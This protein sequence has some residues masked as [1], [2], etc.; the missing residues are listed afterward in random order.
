MDTAN[1]QEHEILQVSYTNAKGEPSNRHIIP[2]RVPEDFI[3]AVD[4]SDLDS[5]KR[6]AMQLLLKE[7]SKYVNQSLETIHS[8]EDWFEV[9]VGQPI[10]M[11]VKWRTFKLDKLDLI[12][13]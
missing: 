12:E 13:E 11:D 9:T 1:L 5:N 3:K 8:F 6:E 10:E 4:V 2:T 7:Y